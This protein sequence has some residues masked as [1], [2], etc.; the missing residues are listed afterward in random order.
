MSVR[1]AFPSQL[2]I[3]VV[4]LVNSEVGNSAVFWAKRLLL[5]GF[6]YINSACREILWSGYKVISL[7]IGAEF[8]GA[9][10][11][12]QHCDGTISGVKLVSRRSLLFKVTD[13]TLEDRAGGTRT[14]HTARNSQK[15]VSIRRWDISIPVLFYTGLS[16][17]AVLQQSSLPSPWRYAKRKTVFRMRSE[18][19]QLVLQSFWSRWASVQTFYNYNPYLSK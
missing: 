14:K 2:Y 15:L 5:H 13:S 8:H 17:R 3:T 6:K 12:D 1:T 19:L 11:A 10:Q 9:V 4:F 18:C 7:M 16:D